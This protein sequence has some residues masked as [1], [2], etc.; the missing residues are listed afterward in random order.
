MLIQ[1]ALASQVATDSRREALWKMR[2]KISAAEVPTLSSLL[3]CETTELR[4]LAADLILRVGPSAVARQVL[5]TEVRDVGTTNFELLVPM[6]MRHHVTEALPMLIQSLDRV[7]QPMRRRVVTAIAAIAGRPEGAG[8]SSDVTS[9]EITAWLRSTVGRR[10]DAAAVEGGAAVGANYRA[11]LA[12]VLKSPV[13][14]GTSDII[15][16]NP[17][18]VLDFLTKKGFPV[19]LAEATAKPNAS[20]VEWARLKIK[21]PPEKSPFLSVTQLASERA[22][23]PRIIYEVQCLTP[24]DPRAAQASAWLAWFIAWKAQGIIVDVQGHRYDPDSWVRSVL[25]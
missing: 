15:G 8:T 12:T 13:T 11:D 22:D 24:G 5:L 14:I 10:P 4:L 19:G 1:L 16:A 21:L 9:A 3:T 7:P 17:I 6:L 2:G 20:P 18:Q 23:G 25:P